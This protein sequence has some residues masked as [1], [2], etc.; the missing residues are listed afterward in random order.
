LRA[1]LAEFGV[2]L[3]SGGHQGRRLPALLFEGET[4]GLPAPVLAVLLAIARRCQALEDEIAVL[5]GELHRRARSDR[6]T[7]RLL[8][9]PGIGPITATALVATVA[10]AKSFRSG[11]ELAAWL[12]LVPRQSSSGGR[13]RLGGITKMGHAY[14]RRLLVVG[15]QAVLRHAGRRADE[16]G[17]RLGRLLREKPRK[18]AAVALANKTA[19][20][21]WVVLARKEAYRSA[22]A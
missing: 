22:A 17:P 3:P 1:H 10:E 14:L 7:Q 13:E 16:A 8:K 15:A 12:G 4:F 20:I 18:V 11:R 6:A 21:V 5:E 2:V 9:I 19:R